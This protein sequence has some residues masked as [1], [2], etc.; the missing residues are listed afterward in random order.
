M[1]FSAPLIPATLVRRYKRFLADVTLSSGEQVTVHVAN[2]GAMTGLMQPGAR[3][4][5]SRSANPARKLG[6]SWELVEVD[7]GAGVELAGVNTHHPNGLVAEALALGQIPELAG[8]ASLRR[9]VKYGRNSRIDL[10][11]EQAGRPPCYVE[12]KNVHL[13][14]RPRLA[15]FPDCV[16]A[17]GARHLDEM[18]AVVAAGAR[19]VMLYVIQIGSAD[20]LA[21]ADDIDPAYA[22]AFDRVRACGVEALARRCALTVDAITIATPVPIVGRE[23]PAPVRSLRRAAH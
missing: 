21:L 17:R 7:L 23:A 5:L 3:I 22:A 8:Y 18:A 2:P 11:L 1:R 13:M 16:T 9:E 10:L 19:A 14:R 4:W 6:H 15:E 20:R 12:I